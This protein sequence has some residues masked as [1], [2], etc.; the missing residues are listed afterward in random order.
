MPAQEKATKKTPLRIMET[1]LSLFNE[2]GERDVTTNHIAAAMGISPGN[3]YYHF[4]NKQEI[5]K[6][7]FLDYEQ[8][9]DAFLQV[10]E[11]RQLTLQ[12]KLNYLINVFQGLWDYRF[13]HR[14]MEY[15]L[16]TNPELQQRYQD[17]FR[18]C[19]KATQA[20]YAGLAEAG[21]IKI[22]QQDLEGLALNTWI[23]VTSWFSFLQCNFLIHNNKPV[24]QD[25]VT[26]GIY[27]VF[28]LERPYLTEEY[29][30]QIEEM[31]KAVVPK[32]DWL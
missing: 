5:I 10:P 30:A 24:T 8:Q 2:Q 19:L 11:D 25:M 18:R 16:S 17:F 1:A 9:V 22:D 3:L 20:I 12:D 26:A 15:L 4:K 27:Q 6:H 14:D 32:P 31:Q 23:V 13:I 7:L 21:I 28:C 29:R